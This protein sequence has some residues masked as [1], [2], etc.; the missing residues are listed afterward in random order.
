MQKKLDIFG[1]EI[2][3]DT[4]ASVMWVEKSGVDVV[5]IRF[6]NQKRQETCIVINTFE[7]Y[8]KNADEFIDEFHNKNDEACA[9]DDDWL[10]GL[11][12]V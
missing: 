8:G 1:Y 5:N 7:R 2:S 3:I 6:K 10:K 4:G 12:P 9:S 11:K